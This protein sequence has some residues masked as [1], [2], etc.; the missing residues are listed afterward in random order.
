[1][2]KSVFDCWKKELS[3]KDKKLFEKE[4]GLLLKVNNITYKKAIKTLSIDIILSRS[5]KCVSQS[6]E[7]NPQSFFMFQFLGVFFIGRKLL[8]TLCLEANLPGLFCSKIKSYMIL[9][10]FE[11]DQLY[12]EGVSVFYKPLSNEEKNFVFKKL[13]EDNN[14]DIFYPY[15]QL[16]GKY[17]KEKATPS[18]GWVVDEER[19]NFLGM[20]EAHIRAYTIKFLSNF[21]LENRKIY[22]PACSTGEFLKTIKDNYKNVYV[23]GQDLSAQMIEYARPKIDEA[24]VGN[25]LNSPLQ[26]ESVDFIFYR[27]LN[28][29]VVST[30]EAH[31]LFFNISKKCKNGGH[32]ILFGHTPVLLSKQ[33]LELLGLN[34]LQCNAITE[35]GDAIFQYYVLKKESE[36][37]DIDFP[38][39]QY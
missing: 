15:A 3:A 11:R 35:N 6:F 5:S 36:F 13:C 32:M 37:P 1:M 34:V 16:Q 17:K 18:E 30:K 14:I 10:V 19:A 28:S 8:S 24:Y 23:I 26:N 7:E 33:W 31:K 27:F 9:G 2:E 39:S 29:E 25:S 4:K 20:G 22:D 21:N 38:L 12:E